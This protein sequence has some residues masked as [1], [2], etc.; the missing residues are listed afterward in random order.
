MNES[1]STSTKSTSGVFEGLP[2]LLKLG[3]PLVAGIATSAAEVDPLLMMLPVTL[4]A[5]C[6][7]MLPVA[8]PPNAVVFA[9][10]QV[11]MRQM[12]RH[13]IVMNLL[14]VVLV[15]LVCYFLGPLLFGIDYAQGVPA[16]A[17]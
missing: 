8:T 13:G 6:A 9:S 3:L 17:K 14:G 2:A 4:S 15:T 10:G 7:F 11:G 5:S 1:D 12:V 16:W